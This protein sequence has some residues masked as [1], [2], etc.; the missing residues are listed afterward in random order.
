MNS[1]VAEISGIELNSGG[2]EGW[3][4]SAVTA[5]MPLI[6][7]LDGTLTPTDT[8]LESGLQLFKRHPL[9]GLKAAFKLL[10]GRAA[11]KDFVAS[12]ALIRVDRLPYCLGL[13]DYLRSEKKKGRRVILATGAA[14]A[15]AE[16][17]ATHLGIFD[18]IIASD[19]AVNVK[20]AIKLEAIRRAVGDDFVYA[21]DSKDDLP[22]WKSA[23]AAILVGTSPRISKEVRRCTAV[24]REFQHEDSG[25]LVWL[26]VLRVHQW[27]KNLLLFVPL[28]TAFGFMNPN[29]LLIIGGA[30]VAM[31]LAASATYVV[32][33]LLDVESDRI[34]P[35]KRFRPFASGQIAI[36]RGLALAGI[37]IVGA[38]VVGGAVSREFLLALVAYVLFTSF[39]SWMLKGYVLIDV[40]TLSLLYTLRI[41][42]GSVALG[43]ETSSWLLAFSVFLFLSLALV[44][45]CSELVSLQRLGAEA[46]EG[47][48]YRVNDLLILWPFG[49]GSA[50]CAVVIF[51]LF[52]N[53]AETRARYASPQLLWLV[54]V[55]L[56]YWL[57]RL[58]I[59]TSRGEMHDD[60]LVYAVRDRAT[61][62]TVLAMV[63]T[64]L[65]AH[66]GF[67]WN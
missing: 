65:V 54:A 11:L 20:G 8:L 49:V 53:A 30:F 32:N 37:M 57:G 46:T 63:F 48:D 41:L 39:Y 26:R 56:V 24:E 14:R 2:T 34:H 4:R 22:I 6:V 62:F 50:L 3:P 9:D 61:R 38:L 43:I 51:G 59:K 66:F 55:G 31:C 15:T 35:R 44:K 23:K 25:A 17:V 42:A 28:L 19:E 7:D 21:G 16:A 58:W 29:N 13:L 47:R 1:P 67:R 40:L 36:P 27:L 52:I 18:G 45:R 5:S 33:D 60:P 12:R 64:T 10:K